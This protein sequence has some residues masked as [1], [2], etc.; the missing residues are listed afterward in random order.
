MSQVISFGG[1]K[2]S[3]KDTAADHLVATRGWVKVGMSDAITEQ[4]LTINPLIPVA[5]EHIRMTELF[6]RVGFVKAKENPEVRRLLDVHGVKV[7]RGMISPTI[8]VDQMV[9]KVRAYLDAGMNVAISGIRFPEEL[10]AATTLGALNVWV[11]RP[12]LGNISDVGVLNAADFD[13]VLE[14][15][16]TL[17]ELYLGIESIADRKY[18]TAG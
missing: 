7:G 17:E 2:T 18:A 3:G 13:V 4:M 11:S 16:G 6:D 9:R 15:D 5:G 8:W 1:I 14:N 12:A 10:V